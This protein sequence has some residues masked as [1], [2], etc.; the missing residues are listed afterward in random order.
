MRYLALACDY[1]GTIATHGVVDDDTRD[2]LGRFRASGRRLILV[3]GRELDDLR[4]VCPDLTIF[5]RIVAE[6]GAVLHDPHERTTR[7]LAPAP[8]QAFIQELRRRGVSPVSVGRVIVASWE[9]QETTVLQTIRDLQLELQVIF[10]KGA[11]MVLPSGVNKATGLEAQLQE[12]GLSAH[13]VAGIGDAEND[14][15]FLSACECGVAVA[16][17][18]P[19]VKERVD[20]VTA[21]DHG[22]GVIELIDRMLANDLADVEPRLAQRHS[23]RLGVDEQGAE[24]LLKPYGEAVLIAGPS[25]SGKSTITTAILEHLCTARYQ[26]CIID[27][28]GDY[29]ELEE[30]VS[31][32]GSDE[33]AMADEAMQV[34]ASPHQNL[35]LNLVD[36]DLEQRPLFFQRMLPL[37]L[38]LRAR[39]AR[40]H[41]VVVDEAHHLLPVDWQPATHVLPGSLGSILMIT[42]HPD[43]VY[44]PAR[45]LMRTLIALGE[46]VTGVARDFAGARQDLPTGAPPK[47]ERPG[48]WAC[49]F[50]PGAQPRWIDVVPPKAE[51]KRHQRKYAEGELGPD[52]SFYFRG[53]DGRLNLRSHNLAMFT[54]VAEGVDD[55]TWL[56]HLQQGDYSRWFREAIKDES[57]AQAAAAA[58]ADRGLSA[59]ESRRRILAAIEE[60]YTSPA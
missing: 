48:R 28:E 3:T 42:V 54:Q 23:V 17:A 33:R 46:D 49:L 37:L 53:P 30:A 60:R 27:P 20:L 9:P 4:R 8:P 29:Q 59:A 40:P 6:N 16:N 56:H 22:R 26:F 44:P 24:A 47:P 15:A 7:D 18:L 58:E 5:H 39:T 55:D 36:L 31:L 38:E 19:A 10:N 32:R 1:D 34:L 45:E 25:G 2:A 14:H 35:V 11:V 51:R 43:H 50:Q 13:N 21:G 52:R 57:L 41:W 12:L